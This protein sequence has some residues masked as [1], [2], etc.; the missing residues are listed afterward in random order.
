MTICRCHH[1]MTLWKQR[2]RGQIRQARGVIS[3]S[4]LLSQ[5]KVPNQLLYYLD[6]RPACLAMN[7]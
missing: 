1:R 5:K 7:N 6:A 2:V 4:A 3:T